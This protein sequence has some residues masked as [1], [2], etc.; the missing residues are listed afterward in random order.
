MGDWSPLRALLFYPVFVAVR[1]G[2]NSFVSLLLLAT[3]FA[4]LGRATIA[5]GNCG[6]VC[7]CSNLSWLSEW[8]FGGD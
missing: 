5:G 2:Q 3:C 6:W 1:L 4:L 8:R 7:S